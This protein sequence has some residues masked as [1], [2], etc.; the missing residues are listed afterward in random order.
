MY[1]EEFENRDEEKDSSNNEYM[2][3]I[4]EELK[5]EYPDGDDNEDESKKSSKKKGNGPLIAIIIA[6]VVVG[7]S[8]CTFGA[9]M[10]FAGSDGDTVIT[11]Q[12]ETQAEEDIGNTKTGTDTDNKY[13]VTD[14]SGVVEDAMPSVVAITSTTFVESSSNDIYDFYFGNGG[15]SGEKQEQQSA[16]SGFIVDQKDNELLI[17]TNNHV[18]EGADKLAIQFYGQKNKETVSGAI[19]GTDD[20]LDV[21]IVSVNM[22]D[23][24]AKIKSGIKKATLGDSSQVKVG[25]GAV[26]IGNALGFGQ[27]V[28]AGVISAVDREV[29]LDGTKRKLIQTDA[30]I[31]GGNSGGALLNQKGEVIGINVAKYSASGASGSIEGMGFAIPISSVKDK[32]S[33]LENEKTRTKNSEESKGYLGISGRTVDDQSSEEYSIPKGV[34]VKEV[35]S[36]EAAEKAG[37]EVNDV[38]TEL[39]GKT[40]ESM[41]ELSSTLDYYKAGET[42]KVVIAS[43]ANGYKN[44]TVK[45]TLGKRP[46]ETNSNNNGNN[47]SGSYYGD[48]SEGSGDGTFSFPW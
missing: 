26:A 43:R 29:D 37:I 23:I 5:E 4:Y 11:N 20:K 2:D 33:K 46:K 18:V 25:N 40:I 45:V 44:K 16:G 36:G 6:I 21:A 14:V 42:V 48:G 3:D 41:D 15:Q 8:I 1:Y 10:L 7:M 22:K 30:P 17:V 38:I 34:I 13:S 28:T 39:D 9:F 31:N 27:S 24:P 19:K 47:N 32:I 35:F 12:Q